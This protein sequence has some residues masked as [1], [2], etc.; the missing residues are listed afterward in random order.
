MPYTE[1]KACETADEFLDY[2]NS[3][4]W[5]RT[6]N[7]YEANAVGLNGFIFRGQADGEWK[8]IP[9]AF[10]EDSLRAYTPQ[11]AGALQSNSTDLRAWLGYHLHSELR[12]V[13]LFLET[14]DRLGIST[15]IDYTNI[16]EHT[17][18]ITAAL[19]QQNTKSYDSPFPSLHSLN[20]LALA[21]HHGVPT[22]L[23]DWTESPYI[24]AYFAAYGV[25]NLVADSMR[26]KSKRFAVLM[27]RTHD[28]HKY[29]ESL[30]VVNA[31]RH[32]NSFLRVQKGLFTHI[33]KAN[34]YFLDHR[35]WPSLE[36]IAEA[37]PGIECNLVRVS[38]PTSEAPQLLLR[39]Y[40]MD[41]TRHSLMPSLD[42]A[43]L[44]CSYMLKLFRKSP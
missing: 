5:L 32:T 30:M 37:T 4:R 17:E 36:D 19:Q 44:A 38:L 15:P 31:P 41:I 18:L 3:H 33:P 2:F 16:N 34:R 35:Q 22:R 24:A 20:Q 6:N 25:S 10:R 12:A 43:A 28:I 42:N 9:S 39:L 1:D 40:H 14:A 27:L 26:I 8:L 21:Q 29:P 11:T 7:E 23:L 13:F